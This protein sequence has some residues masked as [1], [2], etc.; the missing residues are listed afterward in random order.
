MDNVTPG[1]PPGESELKDYNYLALVLGVPLILVII[2][3]NVLVCLSVLT[4]RS[5]KTATNYFIISLAVADLLLAVLVLPLYVYSEFLGGVWTL[6]TSIC[7]ALMTMDVMLCTASI[8]NLCA[9]SV[10]RYIAVV[11]PLKY[12]RNQFSVRQLALITATWVLSLGVA[13]PVIFGLNQVPGRDPSVC[14]L[15]NDQ[16]VVYSSVCSF[17]VPCPVML[18]LY[19]WMFRGLRRWSG[20]SR[21]QAGRVGRPALSLRLRSALQRAKATTT[22]SREKVVYVAPSGLSPTSPSTVSM[23]TPSA[24]PVTEENQ[25]EAAAAPESDPMTTQ[26]DSVSD[27]EPTE[28]REGSS[29]RENGLKSNAAKRGRRNSK[30]SRVS[31]RERKAMKVLPVVV[32]VFLACWTPFFVV[33]VTKVSCGSCDIGPTLISVVTWLGYVNSAVNPII[34]TAFNAEFRNVFHKLLCCRT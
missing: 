24:T 13:S 34:Y 17:F 22:G 8:L 18:I 4:E 23:A 28:R 7:D 27:G 11:V 16:F 5:L 29:R 14:K 30:S 25:D 32:G 1:S 6:S 26:M 9:I 20:R 19:Y 21:S 31:G 33:H 15:E 2:L 10:D 12:N 3:G